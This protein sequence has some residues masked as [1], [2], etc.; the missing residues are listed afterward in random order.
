LTAAAQKF[1]AQFNTQATLHF[2]L[3]LLDC[4]VCFNP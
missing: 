3:V 2:L 4:T 1:W